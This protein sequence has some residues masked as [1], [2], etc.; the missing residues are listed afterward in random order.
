MPLTKTLNNNLNT[1]FF[2]LLVP[3]LLPDTHN[4]F[5]DTIWLKDDTDK[6]TV[7][8]K[9]SLMHMQITKTM[10]MHFE[11]KKN[12]N[13][14]LKTSYSIKL[15]P[16]FNLTKFGD[17]HKL[18]EKTTEWQD[19]LKLFNFGDKVKFYFTKTACDWW[20]KLNILVGSN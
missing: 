7:N 1:I 12:L 15:F 2:W 5:Q 9:M 20:I 11:V 16:W 18:H 17:G 19:S 3:I 14:S 4:H 8:N 13:G 10:F 6:N